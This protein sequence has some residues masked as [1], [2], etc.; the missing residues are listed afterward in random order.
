MSDWS[1]VKNI[2]CIRPDNMGDLVMSGPAL[3]ALKHGLNARIT[4]LTSSMAVGVAPFMPEI[5]ETIVFDLPWV[6]TNCPTN[7]EAITEL[8]RK[9]KSHCFDAAVIFTVYSQNPLP[10]AMIAYQAGIPK[11]LAYCRENPYGLV[12]DWMVDE[13]P[14]SYINHQVDRDLKLVNSVCGTIKDRSL[15]LIIENDDWPAVA[16][17]LT[18]IGITPD[19]PWLIL[20][21]GV[22]EVKRQLQEKLWIEAA[23]SLINKGFQVLLTGSGGER[24]LVTR[25]QRGIGEGAFAAAGCFS[26]RELIT[27]IKHAPLLLSVNTGTV[28]LAA[29]VGT[30]V[31][32]LYAQTNP[33]H[34][35]WMVSNSVIEFPVPIALKSKNEIIRYVDETVYAHPAQMP[36]SSAIVKA[37]MNLIRQPVESGLPFHEKQ[38]ESREISAS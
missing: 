30:P 18:N 29:A 22:S 7:P 14:F 6:K 21:A 38:H 24:E 27:L 32:V 28:H 3:R 33:Q 34:T 31:V 13:E 9:L 8:I 11:V 19:K 20:H 1:N 37:V 17:Q 2:L 25:L 16:N 26:I 12:S 23:T 36:D 15:K 4:V 10:S 5:D 35:P